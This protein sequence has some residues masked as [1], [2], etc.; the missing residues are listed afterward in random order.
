MPI[1]LVEVTHLA[2]ELEGPRDRL[3]TLEEHRTAPLHYLNILLYG[4]AA[5]R[6]QGLQ[7][8][9]DGRPPTCAAGARASF[10]SEPHATHFQ[11]IETY[12]H[13]VLDI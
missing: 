10:S 1:R 11:M 5:E 13:Y 8:L 9:A 6:R 2:Q 4:V 3:P 12:R 7:A